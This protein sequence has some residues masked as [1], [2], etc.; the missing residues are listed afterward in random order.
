M[1]TQNRLEMIEASG[2]GPRRLLRAT[3]SPTLSEVDLSSPS[4]IPGKAKIR[5]A[6]QFS[7]EKSAESL[8]DFKVVGLITFKENA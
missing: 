6:G 8:S 3:G 7:G 5:I 4:R 2:P 1:L